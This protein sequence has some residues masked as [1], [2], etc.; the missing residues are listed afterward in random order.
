MGWQSQNADE[1]NP[2]R[3]LQTSAAKKKPDFFP[4]PATKSDRGVLSSE[5]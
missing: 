3:L 5:Q 2:D 1:F 4:N